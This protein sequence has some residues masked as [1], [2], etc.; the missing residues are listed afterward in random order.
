MATAVVES[1]VESATV[2]AKP[3]DREKTCPLL[4][5]V[6]CS[7]ARH[8]RVTEYMRGQTP[9]NELQIYTWLDCS[10]R[11]LMGLIKEVNTEARRPGTYFDFAVVRP[12][13]HSGT[14]EMRELGSTT[15][16]IKGLDDNKSLQELKF[17]IGDYIDVA[18]YLPD[19]GRGGA[20]GM[21]RGGQ[22]G[23]GRRDDDFGPRGGPP[24]RGYADRDRPMDD[25]PPRRGRW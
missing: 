15:S 1:Y 12:E 19:M 10:L 20:G 16:G 2:I 11:E 4:L 18:V 21:M 23:G 25:G 24:M 17:V 14:F 5:R 9:A 6:F 7:N 3:I 13:Q 8:H 22:R